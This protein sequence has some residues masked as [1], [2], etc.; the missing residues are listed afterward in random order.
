MV[1]ATGSSTIGGVN[2]TGDNEFGSIGFW[3]EWI[4]FTN[5]PSNLTQAG[6][7]TADGSISSGTTIYNAGGTND[8]DALATNA[9][10]SSLGNDVSGDITRFGIRATTTLN[11]TDDGTYTFSVRSD[12]GVILYVDGIPV[13]VD[14]S[15]HAPRTRSGD[16]DLGPG[17]HEIVII[18]FER[19][20]QNVLEV[21]IQSDVTGDYPTQIP[22]QNADV[23]ANA[24]DDVVNANGGSDTVDGGAGDDEIDGG[25]GEDSLDGGAGND[26]LTGGAGDDVFVISEGSD[27][28]TDFGAG[29]SGPID[30]GDQD[31]NDFVDLSG[32]YNATT[33]DD[34]N[35]ADADPGNDFGSELNMLRADAADGAIDG[36]I[37]GIDYSTQIGAIDLT[38]E[39]GGAPISSS[40]LTFDNTNVPCFT[41]GTLIE[42]KDG[43][44][45]I[46]HL[47]IGDL[48]LTS[49]S[50]HQ[51]IKWIG[52]RKFGR[53]DLAAYPKLRP[54]RIKAGA[55]GRSIPAQ[56]L[57]VSR[58]H[59]VLVQSSIARRMFGAE[60]VLVAANKL[61]GLDGIECADDLDC[62]EY[63]HFMFDRHQIVFS[64]DAPTESLFTGKEALKSLAE[65]ARAEIFAIFPEMQWPTFAPEP[66]AFIPMGRQQKRLVA[67]HAKNQRALISSDMRSVTIGAS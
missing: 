35:N 43:S 38:I 17:Q 14:D 45:P 21:D 20:G 59:R 10:A 11:V 13:V 26:T 46:E 36:V 24:G 39:N 67:R 50:G 16:I 41:R 60:E 56:D 51:P 32:F 9:S 44:R 18:Y 65:E 37:D 31:N 23:Q 57:L 25:S 19:T 8:L 34:V 6:F 27:T 1:E 15:L 58:Q 48:I 66:A 29:N 33:L 63:F 49:Q 55:M 5:N 3:F 62:V 7:N 53:A 64:N 2:Q 12:D 4:E 54:I 22:L 47:K 40:N 30:D 52:Q 28:I 61:L 42:T